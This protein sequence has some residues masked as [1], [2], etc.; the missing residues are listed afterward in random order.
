MFMKALEVL[1]STGH[2]KRLDDGCL[3]SLKVEEELNN[4][5]ESLEKVSK[6]S[7]SKTLS[8]RAKKAA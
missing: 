4:S 8:E 2:I 7:R 5:N 3:W 1:I 6:T